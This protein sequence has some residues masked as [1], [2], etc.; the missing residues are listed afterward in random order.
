MLFKSCYL[1]IEIIHILLLTKHKCSCLDNNKVKQINKEYL[2]EHE[3]NCN[4][5]TILQRNITTNNNGAAFI[6]FLTGFSYETLFRI[7]VN[8]IHSNKHSQ[9][10]FI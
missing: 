4:L 9:N 1:N 3:S 2:I 5:L 6:L 10:I 8:V 7:I